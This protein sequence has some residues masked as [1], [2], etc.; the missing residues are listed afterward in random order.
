MTTRGEQ[1]IATR[2]RIVSVAADLLT[3]HGPA[4]TTT[5]AVQREA[6]LSRGALLHHFGSREELLAAAV[7]QLVERNRRAAARA[8]ADA[9]AEDLVDRAL[10]ALAKTVIRPEFS[11]ELGLWAAARADPKLRSALLQQ[12]RTARGAL[13]EVVDE[14]FGPTLTAQS[15]YH[16]V[17]SLTVQFL[18]GLSIAQT[19]RDN[20]SR[21]ESSIKDWA[22][23]VRAALAADIL[24]NSS[25]RSRPAKGSTS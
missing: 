16:R 23:V 24:P 18:R 6:G 3:S 12:A 21:A 15:S 25:E 9:D 4:G 22:I 5:L 1:R 8:I 17:A 7:G 13:Y 11:A 14:A 10:D 19:L 20:P 2:Q